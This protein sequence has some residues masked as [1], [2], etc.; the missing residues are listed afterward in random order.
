MRF[1]V[2][3][4]AKILGDPGNLEPKDLSMLTYSLAQ[5]SLGSEET[6]ARRI[7]EVCLLKGLS[8]FDPEDLTQLLGG[9]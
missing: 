2:Q 8:A 9:K 5:L 4:K 1:I 7:E 3:I 6:L